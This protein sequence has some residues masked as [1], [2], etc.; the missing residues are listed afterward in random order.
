MILLQKMG[1]E[2]DFISMD[3]SDDP[4]INLRGYYESGTI[5]TY[6][7][8]TLET[9][10]R[11]LEHDITMQRVFKPIVGSKD[12]SDA[13]AGAV[14]GLT[15]ARKRPNRAK[16]QKRTMA[17]GPAQVPVVAVGGK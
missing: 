5:Q 7:Y 17:G 3:E 2:T 4:Y 11:Q 12:V 15:P 6:P 13:L 9:E 16:L 10:L 8:P 14:Y 1:I